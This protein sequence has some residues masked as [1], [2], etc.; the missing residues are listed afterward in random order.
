MEDLY[1]VKTDNNHYLFLDGYTGH[2]GW[3]EMAGGAKMYLFPTQKAASEAAG[4]LSGTAYTQ[5]S[6]ISP[7]VETTY[8]TYRFA[9]HS[10]VQ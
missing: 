9:D 10:K 3:S 6:L 5:R 2:W 1:Y 8:H 4:S 7:R